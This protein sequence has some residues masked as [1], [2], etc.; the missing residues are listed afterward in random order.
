MARGYALLADER[1]IGF[2]ASKVF[3]GGTVLAQ[4]REFPVVAANIAVAKR[5]HRFI[6][7][8][9]LCLCIVDIFLL[10]FRT[11]QLRGV[12]MQIAEGTQAAPIQSHHFSIIC[13]IYWFDLR[14]GS[15]CPI[16]LHE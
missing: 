1:V 14:A 4:L 2:C 10:A 9:R 3:V 13:S 7:T 11:L 8:P 5:G 15:G 16:S 6:S 12:P